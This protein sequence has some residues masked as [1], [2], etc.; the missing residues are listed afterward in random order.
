MPYTDFTD[1][2]Q[3]DADA[4]RYIDGST[5]PI[6]F[7]DMPNRILA[8]NGLRFGSADSP[9]S[10]IGKFLPYITGSEYITDMSY[11]FYES[12][13]DGN[14]DFSNF[15]TANAT[16]MSH[17]LDG[18]GGTTLDLSAFDTSNVTDMSYM[19]RGCSFN[20]IDISGFDTSN[21]TNMSHMLENISSVAY[22]TLDFSSWDTSSVTDMS[23]M[24][25]GIKG[26]SVNLDLSS[27]DTSSVTNMARMF[28]TSNSVAAS[29][30]IDLSNWDTSSVTD[31]EGIFFNL[32]GKIWIP[33]TF[34]ATS[35]IDANKK[36]FCYRSSGYP[37]EV[38]TDA[39]DAETQGWG[40]VVVDKF[41]IHYNSTYQD[42]IN[43]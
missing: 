24:L 10:W 16:N 3:D 34:V 8:I 4:I 31:M 39:T 33:S 5:D 13:I 21:V 14:P 42:F 11:M 1:V 15:S 36:P 2:I 6:V 41:N 38:Y 9:S 26:S 18:A 17:M 28:Y 27:F 23:Y 35:V 25:S 29:W 22:G 32:E 19:L 30:S 37:V 12:K 20:S 40:T 7:T 43:A